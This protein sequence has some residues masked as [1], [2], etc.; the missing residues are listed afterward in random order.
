MRVRAAHR[1]RGPVTTS[2]RL[3]G[4][5]DQ[6]RTANPWVIDSILALTFLVLGL[7]TTS[8]RGSV[9]KAVFQP[10]DVLS[11]T[12]IVI[13]SLAFVFV[14]RA[15]FT[16]LCVVTT[17]VVLHSALGYN[18]GITPFYVWVAIAFVANY[19]DLRTTI[20]GGAVVL[21]GLLAL[22]FFSVQG[23][24][25]SSLIFN[26]AL[27]FGVFMLGVTIRSRRLRVRALE[28]RSAALERE[29][30]E[31]SRRAVADE[32]LRIA[33]ELHDVVAHSIGVIAVQAG[34][35]EHVIDADPAEAKRALRAISDVS[36]STLTEIR[37]M[38]GVLREGDEVASYAP[39][40]GLDELARLVGELDRAGLHVEL[41]YEGRRGELPRGVD[42]AAY[43]IIQEA[44]T[45]VLKHA[46][47][48]RATVLIRYEPATLAVEIRDDGRGVNG[49]ATT[50]GHG[51]IGMR[52]RVALY[53]GTLDA[54]PATGG[55]FRVVARLPYGDTE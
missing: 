29:Q 10:R 2:T 27:F 35:G 25:A 55:G 34:V 19:C 40:P 54:G 48:A 32:R 7:L 38:L 16:V 52:E 6:L 28:D 15:P 33:R 17:A 45:N 51:I 44:L 5:A 30:E 31:E 24:S 37:R 23:F 46:G 43:R 36:R 4:I 11:V 26:S 20:A 3:R 39:A 49:A 41:S 18:E 50:G 13:S 42:L 1:Y 14:R 47:P 8:G 12:L 22:F 21:A 53:G 9:P